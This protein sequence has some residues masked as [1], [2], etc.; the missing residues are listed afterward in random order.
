MAASL[1][2]LNPCIAPLHL[3]LTKRMGECM[4]RLLLLSPLLCFLF[5]GPAWEVYCP[6]F[7]G[8]QRDYFGGA[9]CETLSNEGDLR[10]P[11]E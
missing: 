3:C 5:P 9:W 8:F 4:A 11:G 7:R 1:F 10:P 6:R 2:D